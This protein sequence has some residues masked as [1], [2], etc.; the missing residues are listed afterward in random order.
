MLVRVEHRLSRGLSILAAYT[1][2]KEID[3]MVPSVNGFPG[4]W[5]ANPSPQNFY[6]LRSE[7][8][9]A[10]WDTPQTLV[11]SYVYELPFGPGKPLLNLGGAV[12]RFVGGWQINGTR[13]SRADS[14]CKSAEGTEAALSLA[15]D[16][17]TGTVRTRR[18]AAVYKIDY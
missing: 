3:D 12:G 7:R 8:A 4:E 2:S 17:P 11:L 18:S 1:L 16:D 14:L 15:R 13:R 9:L 10:S 6:D 5:F